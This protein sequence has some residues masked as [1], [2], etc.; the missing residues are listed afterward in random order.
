MHV[1]RD[2][3]KLCWGWDM[4]G[5]SRALWLACQRSRHAHVPNPSFTHSR[6]FKDYAFNRRGSVQRT[7]A[8][9]PGYSD[10]TEKLP[11]QSRWKL[12][13]SPEM[14]TIRPP[15]DK[16]PAGRTQNGQYEVQNVHVINIDPEKLMERL[17]LRFGCDF[18][19]HVRTLTPLGWCLL[20]P[21][22]R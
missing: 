14:T 9:S 12:T 6:A 17:R 2:Q 18:E 15:K 11:T 4:I 8:V 13:T 3:N 10:L 19:V 1:L 7:C 5:G 22:C 16:H 20:I 21:S